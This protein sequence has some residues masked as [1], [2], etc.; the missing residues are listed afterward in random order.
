MIDASSPD[1]VRGPAPSLI[2]RAVAFA[3]EQLEMDVP[4][5]AEWRAGQQVVHQLDGAAASFGFA[6]GSANDLADMYC[7][8]VVDGRL[9][10]PVEAPAVRLRG[11]VEATVGSGS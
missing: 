2:E 11:R 7:A 5:V 1:D 4:Y 3:R 9:P 8:R 6:P 10:A